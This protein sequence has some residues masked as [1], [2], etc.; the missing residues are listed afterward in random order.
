MTQW[1]GEMLLWTHMK[2]LI[3]GLVLVAVIIGA[4]VL[5]SG[6]SVVEGSGVAEGVITEINLDSVAL[7]GPALVTLKAENR[8]LKKQL[9]GNGKRPG[10][11]FRFFRRGNRDKD[12][13][14]RA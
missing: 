7:D 11:S 5:I 13:P 6:D 14:S 9:R 8:E 12:S 2:T 1:G 10:K 3:T 4:F